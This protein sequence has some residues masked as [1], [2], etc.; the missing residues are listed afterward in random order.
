MTIGGINPKPE[1]YLAI[2]FIAGFS[3][4]FV[5]DLIGQVEEVAGVKAEA[6]A[7]PPTAK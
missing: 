2:A 6:T 7:A 3:E 1:L 5:P 4:R